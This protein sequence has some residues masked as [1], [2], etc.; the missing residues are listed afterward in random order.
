MKNTYFTHEKIVFEF[1]HIINDNFITQ[2]KCFIY[3]FTVCDDLITWYKVIDYTGENNYES[4]IDNYVMHN[5]NNQV[6]TPANIGKKYWSYNSQNIWHARGA[7]DAIIICVYSSTLPLGALTVL[8][9]DKSK[10]SQIYMVP[11]LSK[12]SLNGCGNSASND[13]RWEVHIE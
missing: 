5:H 2:H 13:M 11:T 10:H 8:C 1:E 6:Y 7:T 3:S 12:K 4:V 9:W